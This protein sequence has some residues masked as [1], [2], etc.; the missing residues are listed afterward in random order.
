MI[1]Q[2]KDFILVFLA[3]AFLNPVLLAQDKA[4]SHILSPGHTRQIELHHDNDFLL[5]TDWY[6]TT[7][8][9]ITYRVLLNELE[10]SRNKRQIS[11]GLSQEYYTPSNVLAD[12]IDDLDR[13]YA[14]YSAI[15]SQLSFSNDERVLDFSL[16]L[17]VSGAISGAEGFQSW[18]HSG[19]NVNDPT[20]VGQIDDAIHANFYARY[21]REWHLNKGP[22]GVFAA[23]SPGL[24]MGTKDIYI[25]NGATFY[26]GKRSSLQNSMAYDQLGKIVPELFFL[27]KFKYRYVMFDGL[28]EGNLVGDNSVF[29]LNPVDHLFTYGCEVSYRKYRMEYSLGYNYSSPKAQTTDLHTWISMAISRNF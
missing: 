17:G 3:F 13:P 5:F 19:D 25:D 16:Q 29:V 2:P 22:F 1:R 8:S 26:F 21:T 24:A 10:E 4:D 7:G 18:F 15:T 12:K 23:W 6:Y 11:V 20:W 27:V 28:L 14:G 9:F